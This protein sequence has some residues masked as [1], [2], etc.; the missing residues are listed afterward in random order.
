MWTGA[1]RFSPSGRRTASGF[2]SQRHDRLILSGEQG[3]EQLQ[4][5]ICPACPAS[6][7]GYFNLSSVTSF[8]K[9]IIQFEMYDGSKVIY[10]VTDLFVTLSCQMT[11]SDILSMNTF[12]AED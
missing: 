7:Q 11:L 9:E 8:K 10:F 1:Q 6:W 2:S 3:G 12:I 5:S 4:E